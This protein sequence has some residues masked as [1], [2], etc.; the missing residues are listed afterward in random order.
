[1]G[2]PL[3]EQAA[4]RRLAD[5]ARRV[6]VGLADLEMDDVP[7]GRLEGACPSG[8]FEGGLGPDPPG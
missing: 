6:E 3:V 2:H 4:G 5:V 8:G 7:A 1:V